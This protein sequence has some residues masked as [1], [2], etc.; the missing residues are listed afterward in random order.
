[1]FVCSVNRGNNRPNKPVSR[2]LVVV[3]SVNVRG[4]S[5][6]RTAGR[7]NQADQGK[8]GARTTPAGEGDAASSR[9]TTTPVRGSAACDS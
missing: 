9:P 8:G 4:S 1:M 6:R 2:V 5:L 3:A 7:H